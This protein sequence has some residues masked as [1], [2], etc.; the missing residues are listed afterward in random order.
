M[1]ESAA[2]SEEPDE[3]SDEPTAASAAPD[4]QSDA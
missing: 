4:V 1:S 2:G 3:E